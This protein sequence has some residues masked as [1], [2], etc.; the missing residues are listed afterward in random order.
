ML[1][2]LTRSNQHTQS[3][4]LFVHTHSSHSLRPDHYTLSIIVVAA[5]NACRATFEAQ[6]HAHAVQT[7]LEAHS[8]LA[9]S[10]L[11]LYSKARDLGSIKCAFEKIRL[12]HSG[13]RR[14]GDDGE[15]EEHNSHI[16]N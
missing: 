3:L 9:N 10:L 13:K 12:P 5:A 7:G 14:R 4:K 6:L 11:S 8:H 2:S 1:A 15:A 16:C